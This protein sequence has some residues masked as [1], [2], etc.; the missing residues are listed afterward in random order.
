MEWQRISVI[1]FAASYGVAWWAELFRLWK[2]EYKAWRWLTLAFMGAGLLAHTLYLAARWT[3]SPGEA[4][5]LLWLAW[6]VAFLGLYGALHYRRVAW[7]VFVLPVVLALIGLATLWPGAQGWPDISGPMDHWL[8]T[9]HVALLVLG[10]VGVC[11]SFVA[12]VMY[13]VQAWRLR[14][15]QALGEGLRLLSL[16]R[17]ERMIRHGV[18]WAFPLWT[19]GVV[20]GMVL[21]WQRRQFSWLDPK[22][23]SGSLLVVVFVLLLDLRYRQHERGRRFAWGAILAFVLLLVALSIET[24]APSWH[25]FGGG[26]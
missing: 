22:V 23:I 18:A 3:P 24:F 15:K 4:R 5:S 12:S 9:A 8:I 11:V 16:E 20:M 7:N 6:I 19:A 25:R 14:H 1:C 13:L 26:S 21:L 10:G 17:L 2:P